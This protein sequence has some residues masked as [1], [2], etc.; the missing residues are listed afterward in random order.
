MLDPWYVKFI[1]FDRWHAA[2]A[3]ILFF[4]CRWNVAAENQAM[5]RVHRINQE[6][7]VRVMRSLMKDSIEERM[8]ELQDS[9]AALGKGS[10]EKLSQ[11]EKRKARLTRLLDLFQVMEDAAW[12]D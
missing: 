3:D 10:M 9:K 5:D 6:C 2:F 11:E 1:E 4:R 7:P 12:T 8:V